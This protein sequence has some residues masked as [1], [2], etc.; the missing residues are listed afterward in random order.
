MNVENEATIGSGSCLGTQSRKM[1]FASGFEQ[2]LSLG[3]ALSIT[4]G[5]NRKSW[6]VEGLGQGA[7]VPD[8]WLQPSWAVFGELCRLRGC[9]CRPPGQDADPDPNPVCAADVSIGLFSF[10]GL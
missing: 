5:G 2:S 7:P 10:Q 8:V 3:V 1:A 4:T 9:E 6:P